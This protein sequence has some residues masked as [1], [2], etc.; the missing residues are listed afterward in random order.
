M[1]VSEEPQE[2]WIGPRGRIGVVIPSTNIAVE[3][4]CQRLI[5]PGVTWHFGR[6]F[7]PSTDLSSDNSFL[8]FLEGIRNT[9]PQSVEAL[10]S[11]EISHLMMGMSAETFWGGVEGNEEFM[12]RVQEQIGDI[13]L[14]TGATA[15]V[16]ALS[17]L[18][19]KKIA[20]LSPYQPVGDGQVQD[21]FEGSGF[22]VVRQ[23]GLRCG[24]ATS[25]AHTPRQRVLDVVAKQLDGDDIDAIVQ[26][27][28]NLTT[29]DFFPTLELMLGKPCIP[30]NI[31][32]AWSALR[33]IGVQDRMPGL[34]RL[35]EEF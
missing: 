6:F 12:S 31:A 4:D 30:I 1:T 29:A 28:T 5:T 18:K 9:I 34:G 35:V 25:I 21:F 3:Y 17:A 13:G 23:V 33:A 24:S 26:V 22:E 11:A 32:T 16:E 20:V 15:M 14:T 8:S 7:T 2:P 27:G 10:M 19:A